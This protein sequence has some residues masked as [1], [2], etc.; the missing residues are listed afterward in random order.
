MLTQ[1]DGW[2]E[3]SY[4]YRNAHKSICSLQFDREVAEE[5]DI[6]GV[7]ARESRKLSDSIRLPIL[8]SS[9]KRLEEPI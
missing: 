6:S 2:E 3:Y 1:I 4:H 5:H 8:A 7:K 9:E